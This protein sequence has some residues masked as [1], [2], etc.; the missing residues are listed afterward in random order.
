MRSADK[1]RPV[2]D[3]GIDGQRQAERAAD[4][5]RADLRPAAQRLLRAARHG[6]DTA[7]FGTAAR[8]AG[9]GRHPD[10]PGGSGPP[11][12]LDRAPEV[13]TLRRKL[14]ELANHQRGAAL[15]AA[16]ALA[17]A[18][19]RPEA[20]GLL[21]VDGH[22]RV[23]SG[24]R[25][26]PKTHIARMHLAAHASA[27]TWIADTDADPVMVVTALPGASLAGELVRLL[28]QLRALVGPDRGATVIFDRGGWSPATFAVLIAAGF[29]ML[30]YRKG[31]FDPLPEA[32]F[33]A[34]T[35]VD[36]EGDA[37]AYQ[38]AETTVALPLPDGASLSL[39]QIH[40]LAADGAQ[41]PIL[42][43]RTDL[44]AAALC[45]RLTRR[46]RQENYFKYARE[47]F[48]LDFA[49]DAADSYATIADDPAR[50]V[51]NPAKK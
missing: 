21:H 18:Q 25:N 4:R 15:P 51:P 11:A 5:V 38:L 20:L 40:R 48:A 43:S 23:Y 13:K 9:R 34:H 50:L 7:V 8:S 3:P 29:D 33:T 42:T 44:P 35:H 31:P 17:H 36:P 26:L 14:T 45:W 27:E 24:G 32:A 28:P 49:L 39:R 12:G 16:L 46:W 37:R 22:T 30:T 10:P 19:T 1:S 41:I 6:V 2:P 47:H